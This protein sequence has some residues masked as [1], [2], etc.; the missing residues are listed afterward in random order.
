MKSPDDH[1]IVIVG[2]TASGKTKLAAKVAD[3]LDGEVI[4]A[5]SRQVYR[6]MDIGTGKD[7]EDYNVGHRKVPYHLIDIVDPGYRYNVYEYQRD[8][9]SV[10]RDIWERAKVPVLCGGTGMYIEAVLRGYKLI[11]VPPD[12]EYRAQL[13]SLTME[14]MTKILKG[15]KHLHNTTDTGSRKRLIRALEIEKYYAGHEEEAHDYPAIKPLIAGIDIGREERRSRIS[16]RLAARL[17]SGMV[18]EVQT[19]LQQ[20]IHKEDLLYYGLEYKFVTLYLTGEIGYGDM[21]NKLETAIHRFAKRQMT[22]FRGMERRGLPVE[23]IPE[24]W[25]ETRKLDRLVNLFRAL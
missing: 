5:D 11:K 23:W 25:S 17:E 19:L 8:F 10:Y 2:P 6:Q 21:V 18:E 14:E 16:R 9:L 4:G 12:K 15:Y 3:R 1:L 24:N 20:G 22:W 7:Y 13:E